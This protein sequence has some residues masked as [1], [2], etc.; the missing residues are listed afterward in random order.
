MFWN[1]STAL[2]A[3]PSPSLGSAAAL[4][5]ADTPSPLPGPPLFLLALLPLLGDIPVPAQ[6]LPGHAGTQGWGSRTHSFPVY[7]CSPCCELGLNREVDE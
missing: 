3:F 4:P 7:F 1:L 5:D 2:P 6:N